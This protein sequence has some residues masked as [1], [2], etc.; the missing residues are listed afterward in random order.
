MEW[1][2]RPAAMADLDR[3][4]QIESACFPP[5]QAASRA[6]IA[7]RVAAWPQHIL[8]GLADG[9]IVGYAMGPVIPHP[10]I[11]DEMFT[12][13]GCHD[14]K[15]AYQSVFSLAVHPDHQRKGFGRLLLNEM[16]AQ[17]RREGRRAVTLTCRTHKVAYY[18]S[19]GFENR[20]VAASCHG[21]VQWFD[22]LLKL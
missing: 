8:L 21:G 16:I 1:T 11:E 20:G 19:F 17:A 7:G 3:L 13:P 10:T 9:Q 18:E 22:M 12:D 15:A 2:I 5:E 14:E 6:S 4:S